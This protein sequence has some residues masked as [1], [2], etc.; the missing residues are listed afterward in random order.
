MVMLKAKQETANLLNRAGTDKMQTMSTGS[1]TQ[2]SEYGPKWTRNFLLALLVGIALIVGLAVSISP[3]KLVYVVALAAIPLAFKWPV[4]TALGSVGLLLQFDAILGAV[5]NDS[6]TTTYT[7]FVA[8]GAGAL[9]LVRIVNGRRQAPPRAAI[10][11]VLLIIWATTTI[12][13]AMD[14]T[15]GIKLLPTAWAL[16]IFYL[17]AVSSRVSKKQLYVV[18]ILTALGGCAAASWAS[19]GYFHGTTWRDVSGRASL[20]LDDKA[21]DPNYFAAMLLVPLSLGVGVYLSTRSRLLKSIMAV[22]VALTALSIFLSMSRGALV[23]L[24]LMFGVY[25][26]R[27]GVKLRT[28]A[29]LAVI[30]VLLAGVAPDTFWT[31]LKPDSVR[32]GAGRTEVWAAASQMLKHHYLAG[33]GL[34]NFKIAYNSYAGAAPHF[35]GYFKDSHN[36]YLNVLAEQG[37]LGLFFFVLALT[38]QFLPMRS[39]SVSVRAPIP[40]AVSCEAALVAMLG[41]AFFI[42]FLWTKAFWFTLILCTFVSRVDLSEEASPVKR[43]VASGELQTA[44]AVFRTPYSPLHW[45]R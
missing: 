8:V 22:S 2:L 1:T 21:A 28:L 12:L 32:T 18:I 6:G 10:F 41:A 19:W 36:T 17:V 42:D 14:S 25:V 23:A 34:S 26:Y 3:Q 20:V 11:W 13:W 43:S 30:L 9:L 4:E 16:L 29:G 40:L 44:D 27:L 38:Y 33:V 45:N 37:V 39:N 31:R 7:W 35:V 5:K 24:S 15:A